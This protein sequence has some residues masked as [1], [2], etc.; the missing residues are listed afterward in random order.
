MDAA[1]TLTLRALVGCTTGDELRYLLAAVAA[2]RGRTDL[3]SALQ[4][5]DV[6]QEPCPACGALVFPSELQRI[7][8]PG[9]A[10]GH[11]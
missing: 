8:D 4:N 10:L 9:R 11:D 2:F 6:I 7:V 5:L 3:A 1:R